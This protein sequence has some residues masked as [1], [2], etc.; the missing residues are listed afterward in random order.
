MRVAVG[1]DSSSSLTA[2][3]VSS[4]M[5]RCVGGPV[6][7]DVSKDLSAFETSGTT[8]PTTRHALDV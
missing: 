3:F 7:P 4:A 5:W 1:L 6:T 8:C 2:G